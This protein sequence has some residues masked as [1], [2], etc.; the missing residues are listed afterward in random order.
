MGRGE[1]HT[2]F[3][4]WSLKEIPRLEDPAVDGRIVLRWIFRKRDGIN[5]RVS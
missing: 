3:W 4:R 2:E 5:L 1:V